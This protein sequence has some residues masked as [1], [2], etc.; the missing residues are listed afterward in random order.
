MVLERN[1]SK[2]REYEELIAK[3]E[4]EANLIPE[5]VVKKVYFLPKIEV[6]SVKDMEG[7]FKGK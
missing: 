5:P 1:W 6:L 4:R 7:I 3:V 2:S